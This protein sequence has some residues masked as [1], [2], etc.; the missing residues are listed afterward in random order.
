MRQDKDRTGKWLLAHHGDAI[1]KL[2]GVTGFSSWKPL[3]AERSRRAG[4][5]T[6]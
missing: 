5:R 2:G 1:L 4:P 6:G 3:Q